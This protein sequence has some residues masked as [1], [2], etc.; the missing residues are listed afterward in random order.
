MKYTD[1]YISPIG[2]IFLAADDA[3]LTELYFAKQKAFMSHSR[4]LSVMMFMFFRSIALPVF[5]KCVS[6]L[7]VVLLAVL[8]FFLMAVRPPCF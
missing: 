7:C 5:V 2:G 3:C 4:K 8:V 1:Y 6:F